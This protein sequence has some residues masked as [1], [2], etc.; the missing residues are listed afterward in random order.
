MVDDPAE[1]PLARM[2]E[3]SLEYGVDAPVSFARQYDVTGE[4]SAPYVVKNSTPEE[5]I[6]LFIQLLQMTWAHL[7]QIILN[8]EVNDFFTAFRS[9]EEDEI[10]TFYQFCLK[11]YAQL[12]DSVV[13]EQLVNA[14]EELR[15]Y[16]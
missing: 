2:M 5:L 15:F 14:D 11:T 13:A 3:L 7:S 16:E 12:E 4:S 8:P 6:K 9:L 10:G 1:D